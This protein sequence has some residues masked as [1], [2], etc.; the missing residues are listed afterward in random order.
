MSSSPGSQ[1][2]ETIEAIHHIVYVFGRHTEMVTDGFGHIK[3][4]FWAM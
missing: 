1:L 3:L 4:R 2:S